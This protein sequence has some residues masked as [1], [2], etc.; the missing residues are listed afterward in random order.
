SRVANASPQVANALPQQT[1]TY[2]G[3]PLPSG[4]G[5]VVA[6]NLRDLQRVRFNRYQF[7]CYRVPVS[8]LP[9]IYPITDRVIG[10]NRPHS[11]LARDLIA[12]GATWIQI[13]DK[14]LSDPELI[15]QL[16]QILQ[17]VTSP[18]VKILVN[19]R[20][21]IALQPGV[22][23]LHLG[24]DDASVQEARRLL[25]HAIIGFST[26]SLEQAKAA[27]SLAV[28]YISVGPIF[29][30]Q[31]KIENPPMGIQT[32]R[33]IRQAVSKP[34]VAIGGITLTN[35]AEVWAAGA[36]SV[37][38]ISDIMKQQDIAGRIA[39]YLAQW[40]KIHA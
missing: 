22:S 36:D 20:V 17:H 12:G 27:D 1:M 29:P 3:A 40:Q 21:K 26:H 11:D 14:E 16:R 8:L 18:K 37:A 34:L 32:L 19:D 6:C 9:P 35:V 28:D 25:P 31:T 5:S 30:T 13:R 39:S 4:R 15:L 24:Q 38:V 23:G 10:G 33:K 2:I 7:F